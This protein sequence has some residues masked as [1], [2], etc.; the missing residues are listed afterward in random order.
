VLTDVAPLETSEGT[1]EF[2]GQNQTL[3]KELVRSMAYLSSTWD[4]YLVQE[5]DDNDSPSSSVVVEALSIASVVINLDTTARIVCGSDI[6]IILGWVSD[7]DD[8]GS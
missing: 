6:A 2:R 1:P 8:K 5:G 7:D 3:M 4:R